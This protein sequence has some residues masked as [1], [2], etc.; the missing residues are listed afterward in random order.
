MP[1]LPITYQSKHASTLYGNLGADSDHQPGSSN[2]FLTLPA[3][4]S[5]DVNPCYLMIFQGDETRS[6]STDPITF[7]STDFATQDTDWNFTGGLNQGA[8]EHIFVYYKVNMSTTAAYQIGIQHDGTGLGGTAIHATVWANVRQVPSCDTVVG[9]WSSTYGT[10][11]TAQNNTLTVYSSNSMLFV[12][13]CLA[14]LNQDMG[15]FVVNSDAVTFTE[16]YDNSEIDTTQSGLGSDGGGWRHAM[17]YGSLSMA[18]SDVTL[19]YYNSTGFGNRIVGAFQMYNHEIDLQSVDGTLS[20]SG[21]LEPE[22]LW[23]RTLT[24]VLSFSSRVWTNILEKFVKAT[25]RLAMGLLTVGTE[26][27]ADVDMDVGPVRSQ[28][29][30][31][32]TDKSEGV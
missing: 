20:L 16:L 23:K 15:S 4:D 25:V 32:M 28:I 19:R 29:N 12:V 30:L 6:G 5:D 22:T 26:P 17:A 3:V 31:P 8:N 9:D 27:E 11:G 18:G 13:G 10:T 7:W 2:M 24:G 21:T 1:N 14:D